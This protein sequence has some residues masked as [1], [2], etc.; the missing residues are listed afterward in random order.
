MEYEGVSVCHSHVTEFG[1]YYRDI[2]P[3]FDRA[4]PAGTHRLV[5]T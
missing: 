3:I 2:I 5:L 4:L 1:W